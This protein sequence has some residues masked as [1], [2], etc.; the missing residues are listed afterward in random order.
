[1][2]RL[3]YRKGRIYESIEETEV[4]ARLDQSLRR[5]GYPYVNTTIKAYIDTTAKKAD[6]VLATEAGPRARFDSI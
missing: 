4:I 1:L 3:P 5:D 2:S 6:L